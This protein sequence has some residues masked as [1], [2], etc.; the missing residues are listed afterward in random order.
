VN[1]ATFERKHPR[2][3][4]TGEW[5]DA[6]LHESSYTTKKGKTKTRK[7][8]RL[9]GGAAL[10]AYVTEKA[11]PSWTAV[12]IAATNENR[13]Q[14]RGFDE[15]GRRQ[16]RRMGWFKEQQ[17]AKKWKRVAVVRKHV[18][19][20]VNRSAELRAEDPDTADVFL[21]VARMGLRPG[22]D[23]DTG[24]EHKGYGATTLLGQHV[25]QNEGGVFLTFVPGKKKG[26]T[27]TLPV[28]DPTVAQ[29]LLARKQA[30][31]DDGRLFSTSP[32]TLRAHVKK[33]G[34]KDFKAKDLRTAIG[35][36][37][38]VAEIAKIVSGGQRPSDDKSRKAAVDRVLKTVAAV[39]GNTPKVAGESYVDPS[40]WSEL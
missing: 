3:P 36:E 40:V 30:A 1:D 25:V 37:T 27:I 21:L 23:K 17:D 4:N 14:I 13:Y 7:E 6:E 19:D 11:A 34:S 2:D 24:A 20:M 16:Q 32:E 29:M 35:T 28:T 15:K 10:P 31:G 8:W 18:A 9:P 38:A 12:Q 26:K 5:V 39:L 22:S 33:I